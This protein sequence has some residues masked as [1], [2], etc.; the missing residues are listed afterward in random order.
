MLQK[1]KSKMSWAQQREQ[2]RCAAQAG[3]RPRTSGVGSQILAIRAADAAQRPQPARQAGEAAALAL[4]D[5]PSAP[6][7]QRPATVQPLN[8]EPSFDQLDLE[9]A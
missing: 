8:A 6:A 5:Q 7:G 4:R 9:L 2:I 3:V 1:K